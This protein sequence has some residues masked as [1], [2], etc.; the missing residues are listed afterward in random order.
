LHIHGCQPEC[1]G[2]T[3]LV[4]TG[5]ATG[6]EIAGL[7]KLGMAHLDL[8]VIAAYSRGLVAERSRS[9]GS[10]NTLFFL[11][12]QEKKDIN[13]AVQPWN[14]R[15]LTDSS[16]YAQYCSFTPVIPAKFQ[17]PGMPTTCRGSC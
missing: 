1:R 5:T 15:N 16:R 11:F 3:I 6:G 2:S 17:P 7:L 4:F 13:D 9:I 10:F 12:H 14:T 8:N